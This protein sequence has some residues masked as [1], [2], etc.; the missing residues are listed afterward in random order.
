M[1][2]YASSA[3][4]SLGLSA[5]ENEGHG[6]LVGREVHGAWIDP[7]PGGVDCALVEEP[8]QNEAYY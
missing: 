1:Y 3:R 6:P 4:A 8:L 2:W 5:H 7:F